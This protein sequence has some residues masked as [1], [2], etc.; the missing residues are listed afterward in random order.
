MKLR[1]TALLLA[2]AL[3][4]AACGKGENQGL[5][6][7]PEELSLS[8]REFP[9][10]SEEDGM[11]LCLGVKNGRAL[12]LDLEKQNADSPGGRNTV[13]ADLS[14]G[15]WRELGFWSVEAQWDGK[16]TYYWV[17]MTGPVQKDAMGSQSGAAGGPVRYE[18]KEWQQEGIWRGNDKGEG[19]LIYRFP[20]GKKREIRNLALFGDTLCWGERIPDETGGLDQ[21]EFCLLNLESL[22]VQRRTEGVEYWMD[23]GCLFSLDRRNILR[24][25]NLSTGEEFFDRWADSC[26][27]AFYRNGRIIWNTGAARFQI[28]DCK[29]EETRDLIDPMAGEAEILWEMY[30]LRDRYLVFRVT[31]PQLDGPEQSKGLRILDLES[32]EVLYRSAEDPQVEKRENW[33]YSQL[34]AEGDTALLVGQEHEPVEYWALTGKGALSVF[35]LQ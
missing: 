5:P 12:F 9:L 14:T 13:E 27:G 3:L 30:L 11:D 23:N 10:R 17:G 19:E 33:Y 21:E 18:W 34:L 8:V 1:F 2:L 16:D 22:V 31:E 28:Y 32:G 15:E 35:T 6:A 20:D 24:A 7:A 4:S 26:S 25:E 29:T